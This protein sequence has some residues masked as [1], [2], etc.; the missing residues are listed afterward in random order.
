MAFDFTWRCWGADREEKHV[1]EFGTG[2]DECNGDI[3]TVDPQA[4]PK[5]R[6]CAAIAASR[7]SCCPER[8]AGSCSVKSSTNWSSNSRDFLPFRH[9]HLAEIELLGVESRR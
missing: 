7:V 9:K 4:L 6:L 1:N 8:L 3:S 5:S 2:D